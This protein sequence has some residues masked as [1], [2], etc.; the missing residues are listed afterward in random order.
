MDAE[1]ANAKLEYFIA[2]FNLHE[3]YLDVKDNNISFDDIV[4]FVSSYY[5]AHETVDKND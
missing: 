3:D 2:Y 5:K 1:I 4:D